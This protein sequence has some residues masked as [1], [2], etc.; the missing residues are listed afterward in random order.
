LKKF[1]L[2]EKIWVGLKKLSLVK[3]TPKHILKK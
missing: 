1:E 3:I 2:V